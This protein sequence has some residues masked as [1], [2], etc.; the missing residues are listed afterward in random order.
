MNKKQITAIVF[1]F[2][3]SVDSEPYYKKYEVPIVVGTSAMTI[4]D[5]IYENLDGTLSYYDHAGCDLGICMR[6]HGRINGKPGLLFQTIVDD[7]VTIEPLKKD[8][9]LKD[10]VYNKKK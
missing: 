10:L 7:D 8:M 4:L 5:Y 2:D 6:C 3:P 1:R 9:V